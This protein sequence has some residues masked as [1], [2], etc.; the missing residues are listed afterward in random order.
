[1]IDS[2][3]KYWEA[4]TTYLEM[5]MEAHQKFQ[6]WANANCPPERLNIR[7]KE[8]EERIKED[9]HRRKAGAQADE[10]PRK[11]KTSQVGRTEIF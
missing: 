11:G 5:Q 3:A 9:G 7:M 10:R 1:M 2:Q 8:V 6:E 4:L